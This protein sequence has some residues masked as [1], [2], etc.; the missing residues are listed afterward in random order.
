MN[1][2]NCKK[3]N[4][5]NLSICPSCGRMVGDT[6]AD[7]VYN[8]LMP[9]PEK[10]AKSYTAPETKKPGISG[11]LP[12]I[13][14]KPSPRNIETRPILTGEIAPAKTNRTLVEFQHKQT[15][16]PEWRLQL[17]NAVRKRNGL[18]AQ[19]SASATLAAVASAEAEQ[20]EK[21][22]LK[23]DVRIPVRKAIAA[24][25]PTNEI[26]S[27]A[28]SRIESSRSRYYISDPQYRAYP[29]RNASQT[30]AV[31][32]LA[33][34]PVGDETNGISEE[35][36][37]LYKTNS[38]RHGYDTNELDPKFAEARV[39]S[40][41]DGSGY[42]VKVKESTSF[43]KTIRT[44]ETAV[45]RKVYEAT[46][47]KKQSKQTEP[48][49]KHEVAEDDEE[50]DVFEDIAT[51]PVRF[52]ASL[53]DFILGSFLTLFLLSPFMLFGGEWFSVAGFFGFL[54]VL[55]CVMFIYLTLGIGLF[56]KTVGMRIFSLELIDISG[57]EYPTFH[58]AAVN[59]SVF[60]LSLALFGIG[61]ISIFFDDD[62]R[63]VHNLFS[64]TVVVKE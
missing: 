51:I 55:C 31:D 46:P 40:S 18:E 29:V 1:C 7:T 63:A 38:S 28:L 59:S 62:R 45:P 14:L 25:N 44:S 12:P 15:E 21:V 49:Y 4:I 42:S 57:D 6:V 47:E 54:T 19:E 13:T 9:L 22:A 43:P 17:R 60:L 50:F 10:K 34:A 37:Q 35:D 30:A 16:L 52:N 8:R 58:Q 61:F 2:P 11:P 64:D 41:F 23:P 26:L 56:G 24:G 32:E 39:V 27:R 33:L 20:E 48:V 36:V 5:V 3:D 53:F